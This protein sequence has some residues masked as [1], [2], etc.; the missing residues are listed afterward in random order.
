MKKK[1]GEAWIFGCL[2]LRQWFVVKNADPEV[3]CLATEH[4]LNQG[5]ITIEGWGK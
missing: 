5:G 2:G 3:E 4:G 1:W